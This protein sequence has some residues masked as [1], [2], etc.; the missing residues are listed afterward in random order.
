MRRRCNLGR[1]V[2][3]EDYNPP[4]FPCAPERPLLW[5]WDGEGKGFRCCRL[6]WQR[7]VTLHAWPAPGGR[8]AASPPSAG[9]SLTAGGRQGRRAAGQGWAAAVQRSYCARYIKRIIDFKGE[10]PSIS[11]AD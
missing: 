6:Q 1:K 4:M 7:L 3:A 11:S 10:T 9:L 5:P 2:E 8:C